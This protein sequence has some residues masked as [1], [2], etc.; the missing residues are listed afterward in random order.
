MRI[1]MAQMA[2][3]EDVGANLARSLEM[4]EMA[5]EQGADLAF[6]PEI[7]L[8]PFFPKYEG[9]D[10][11]RWLVTLGGREV[12]ALCDK[13]REL[14]LWASPNVY[15]ELGG[16]RFDASLMID[17]DGEIRGISKMVNIFQAECFYE[18][19][20]YA[21][22]DTGF[23]VYDT[24][25]AKVGVVICFDRHIPDSIRSCAKGGADV[26][27]IPTANLKSEP[28]ELFE[29]EVRVQ[30]FQNTVAVA[31]CNRVGEEDGFVFAGESLLA[32]PDGGLLFK[33]GDAEGVFCADLDVDAVRRVRA[34]R[35]WLKF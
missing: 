14:S 13:C 31:M 34:S 32:A 16:K 21:P 4:L 29:W 5:K 9:R 24:P 6:F 33:T 10:A 19:D 15:L 28:M 26:V 20:Y 2:M 27:L 8:S 17:S 22:S 35:A 12:K 3:T 11:V 23:I 25:F 1:A 18:C 7:Q 30:A